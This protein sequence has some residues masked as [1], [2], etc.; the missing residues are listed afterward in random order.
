M[1]ARPILDV[2]HLPTHRFD[3]RSTLWWG[4]LLLIAIETTMFGVLVA[5]YFYLS[6]FMDVFPPPRTQSPTLLDTAPDLGVG[7]C[8]VVLLVASCLPMYWGDRASRRLQC[9]RAV[10]WFGLCLLLG[11]ISIALRAYEFPATHFRWDSNA[12]GSLVWFLLGF[13]LTHLIATTLELLL[14]ELWLIVHGLDER[15]ALDATVNAAYW[16]W[17]AGVWVPLYIVLYFAPR[18]L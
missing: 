8:N 1:S 7:T 9:N 12:Y 17:M 16:Y 6:M 13:H 11:V 15:R 14:L 10:L 2:S 5:S 3:H 4:N 18:V